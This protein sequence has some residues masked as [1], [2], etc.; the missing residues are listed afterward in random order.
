MRHASLPN[1]WF[2]TSGAN[3]EVI[4]DLEE[5][6]TVRRIES[7]YYH[8]AYW[9]TIVPERVEYLVSADGVNF[10][11]VGNIKLM[12]P[13]DQYGGFQRD[14]IAEFEPEEARYVK[15]IAHSIGN[16]PDWHPGAGQPAYMLVDEI[17]V[18]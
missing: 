5:I 4:I 7:G 11:Q 17:V 8:F 10:K 12:L 2:G 16:T 14:V 15:V 3:L 18:E 13:I 9:R 1:N 6:K